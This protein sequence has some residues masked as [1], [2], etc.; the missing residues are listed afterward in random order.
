MVLGRFQPL[1]SGHCAMIDQL[2]AEGRQ[3]VVAIRATPV[4]PDNP[5]TEQERMAMLADAYGDRITAIVVP[6][7]TELV[8]GR[9][10]G[11]TVRRVQLPAHV[12]A[13]SGT[14]IRRGA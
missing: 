8:H 7:V 13:I 4:G 3:V 6:D 1:H 12:E 9:R 14:D 11:W 5:Y 10:P 2:L